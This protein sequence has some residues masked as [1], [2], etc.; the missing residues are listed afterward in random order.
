MISVDNAGSAFRS[1]NPIPR[2]AFEGVV[3]SPQASQAL[4]QITKIEPERTRRL[5]LRPETLAAPLVGIAAAMAIA[6]VLAISGNSHVQRI[7]T[8]A[9]TVTSGSNGTVSL[10]IDKAISDP[11]GLSRALASQGVPNQV[12]V[13]RS[14]CPLGSDG[15]SSLSASR[16]VISAGPSPNGLSW[17]LHPYLMPA[18]SVLVVTVLRAPGSSVYAVGVHLTSQPPTCI[19]YH[20]PVGAVSARPVKLSSAASVS[21]RSLKDYRAGVVLMTGRVATAAGAGMRI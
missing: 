20:Q 3:R 10:V 19:Q 9:Y 16:E 2:E 13:S 4:Q 14:S 17:T 11:S 18:G 21:L 8:A 15:G 6:V 7:S 5:L 1:A 12:L